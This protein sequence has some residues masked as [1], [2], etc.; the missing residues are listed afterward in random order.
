MLNG[1]FKSTE[2][3]ICSMRRVLAFLFALTAIAATILSI[4]FRLDKTL[5]LIAIAVPGIFSCLMMFFTTWD[6][7]SKVTGSIIKKGA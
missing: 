7:I 2:G 1:L 3:G 6:D 5:A 4:I